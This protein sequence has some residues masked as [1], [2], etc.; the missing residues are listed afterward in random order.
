MHAVT[1]AIEV[2]L[3]RTPN[4]ELIEAAE[5]RGFEALVTPDRNL[6]Y[7]QNFT[8]RTIAIVVL[9]SG[10]WSTVQRQLEE[11]VAAIDGAVP[12]TYREILFRKPLR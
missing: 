11:V 3:D 8:G 1:L 9:P 2:S 6:R 5:K 12:G 7:Q 10:K 4:G